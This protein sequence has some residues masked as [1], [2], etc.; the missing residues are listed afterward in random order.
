MLHNMHLVLD[1]HVWNVILL[2]LIVHTLKLYLVY[3]DFNIQKQICEL[4]LIFKQLNCEC[5]VYN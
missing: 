2:L 3:K 4:K 5:F 1:I